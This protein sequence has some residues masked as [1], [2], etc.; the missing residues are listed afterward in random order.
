MA[1]VEELVVKA[2]PEGIGETVDSLENMEAQTEESAETMDDQASAMGDLS[3]KFAG[4]MGAITAGFAVVSGAL[5]ARVPVLGEA[6]AG[7]GAILTSLGLKVDQTL[8]PALSPL[9]DLFF[10]ISQAINNANG[11]LGT[12]IGLVTTAVAIVTAVGAAVAGLV[13][14]FLALGG[15]LSTVAS[16]AGTVV[17]ALGTIAGAII[18]LPAL[19][20]GAIVALLGFAVAY[21]RNWRGTREFTNR[22][23]AKIAQL[24]K[25]AF[26]NFI[27]KT[28]QF[29]GEFVTAA[30]K[31]FNKVRSNTAETFTNLIADA[32]QFGKDLVSNFA[33]GIRDRISEAVDAASDLASAVRDRLP[34]SPAETGPLSDLGE[35][36]PGLV[37][38][39][40]AGID[41]NVGTIKRSSEGL[42][43]DAQPAA[44]AL[45]RQ[46][47]K[48]ILEIEGRQVERATRDFRSDGTDLR[49]RYG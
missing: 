3:N 49:G 4:A 46:G 28:I 23:V 38:T 19:I 41:N 12:L 44:S 34:G 18:S 39:F 33:D 37:N 1:T 22:I 16:A 25:R 21:K 40:A 13:T 43:E 5:L 11:P 24:V 35:T 30:K 27:N 47:G 20:A 32:T 42:A 48:T 2:V 36:G 17:S 14:T 45:D 7:L 10:R 29:L 15:S 26:I 31:K 6:A 9:T 8:R